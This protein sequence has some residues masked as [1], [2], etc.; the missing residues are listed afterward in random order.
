MIKNMLKRNKGLMTLIIIL[1]ISTSAIET[2]ANL[3][4]IYAINAIIAK[5][6]NLFMIL[7]GSMIL[8]YLLFWI[9]GYS[10]NV[11]EEKLI[12][13]ENHRIRHAYIDNQIKLVPT[14]NIDPDDSINLLTNDVLLYD[15]QYLK[16]FFKLFN[17]IFGI[18]FASIALIT[19]HW[20]LFLLS[21]VMTVCLML[22]PKLVSAR[23]QRTTK[24][25]SE[26]ND[27]LLQVLNDWFKGSKDLLWNGA[28]SQLWHQTNKSFSNLEDS[29]VDQKK[30]QQTA[31]QFGAFVNI[32]AQAFIITLAGFLAIKKL[33][34]IGV[35]FS[36][37]N[38]A[39]QLFGAVSIATNSIILIQS[40][41]VMKDKLAEE[42]KPVTLSDKSSELPNITDINTIEA[43]DLS[44]TYK[45]GVSIK[46]PDFTVDQG[47][48]VLI[49]GPS[50]SGKTTLIN[51]LNGQL[52][53]YNGSLKLNQYDYS[54]INNDTLLNMIG[55][56]PQNYHIFNDS[57]ANNITLYNSGLNNDKTETAIKMAQLNKKID[58]L[59]NGLNT[60]IGAT[61][62][63]LSG[64][65]MQRVSLARFFIRNQPILIVDEGTSALDKKNAEQV[66]SILTNNTKLTLFVITHSIDEDVLRMFN[67][68]IQ[69]S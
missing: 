60:K 17:C 1:A 10:T 52:K 2:G 56:Q 31:S 47:D 32:V 65:E 8:G 33:V 68:H 22:L 16:G 12:Q 9:L 48:K 11:L 23:L 44:Y 19:L 39:F 40:G 35:V 64:G 41:A 69:L 25:I 55:L 57:I 53:K 62:D 18:T 50:G 49:T 28:L 59:K 21:I 61:S 66:M 27:S 36:A 42:T 20:S 67:K 26:N 34:S 46:Y 37:G 14:K 38:L 43:K 58:S 5:K 54:A 3:I 15:Q 7:I 63:V 51:L 29:Y 4:L 13:S 6:I 45:D 24:K 30:A